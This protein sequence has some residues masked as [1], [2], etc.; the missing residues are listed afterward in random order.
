MPEA[1]RAAGGLE[2]EAKEDVDKDSRCG[3]IHDW[4][5]K[6]SYCDSKKRMVARHCSSSSGPRVVFAVGVFV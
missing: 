2:S 6:Y 5:N 3:P 1:P 4:D